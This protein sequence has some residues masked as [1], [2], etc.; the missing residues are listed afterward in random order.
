VQ[1]EVAKSSLWPATKT[2]VWGYKISCHS[3]KG[4]L[5]NEGVKQGTPKSRFFVWLV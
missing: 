5:S 4:I 3:D 2:T 1:T